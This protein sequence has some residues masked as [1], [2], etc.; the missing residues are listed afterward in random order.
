MNAKLFSKPQPADP[1]P[2]DI[3]LD[4]TDR[5][6]VG[7]EPFFRGRDEEYRIFQRA[8]STLNASRIGGG[9]T[10]FQGAPGQEKQL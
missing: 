1:L 5:A 6:E 2:L 8:V 9:T 3:W 10:I 4:D 7:R